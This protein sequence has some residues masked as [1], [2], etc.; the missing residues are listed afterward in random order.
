MLQ[1]AD[2]DRQEAAPTIAAR[3]EKVRCRWMV[4][5]QMAYQAIWTTWQATI[6]ALLFALTCRQQPLLSSPRHA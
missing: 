2:D 1:S 5:R 4:A 3:L 6:P